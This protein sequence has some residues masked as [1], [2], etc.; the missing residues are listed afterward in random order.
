MAD[1]NGQ[2]G[3]QIDPLRLCFQGIQVPKRRDNLSGRWEKGEPLSQRIGRKWALGV[4]SPAYPLQAMPKWTKLVFP[5]GMA[6]GGSSPSV[7]D[8]FLLTGGVSQVAGFGFLGI[9]DIGEPLRVSE[10]SRKCE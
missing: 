3:A 7:C 5:L 6:I 1:P 10:L 4:S 9:G 8:G 2:I